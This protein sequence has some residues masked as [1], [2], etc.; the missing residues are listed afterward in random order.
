MQLRTM[1]LALA[2]MVWAGGTQAA[3]FQNIFV[4]SDSLS[5]GGNSFAITGGF[6]PYR[7]IQGRPSRSG[8][9][10]VSRPRK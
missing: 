2:A 7:S 5:D 6:P 4:F 8:P 9:L 10:T 1:T 3:L